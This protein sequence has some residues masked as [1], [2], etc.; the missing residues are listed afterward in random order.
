MVAF[1][2]VVEADPCINLLDAR[3]VGA[4]PQTTNGAFHSDHRLEV[5]NDFIR[6]GVVGEVG[7]IDPVWGLHIRIRV[8]IEILNKKENHR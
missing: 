7:N 6:G 8:F 1:D 4:S 2:G 5:R 3:T